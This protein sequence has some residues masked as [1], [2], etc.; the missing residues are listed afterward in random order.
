MVNDS[1]TKRFFV[2][3]VFGQTFWAHLLSFNKQC[4]IRS[5]CKAQGGTLMPLSTVKFVCSLVGFSLVTYNAVTFYT[6]KNKVHK[7]L[8]AYNKYVKEVCC[9]A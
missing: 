7:C 9:I 4:I 5:I 2:H 8:I 3:Q 1:K 6:K